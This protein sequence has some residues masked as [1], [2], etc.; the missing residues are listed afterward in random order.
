MH[1]RRILFHQQNGKRQLLLFV[2]HRPRNNNNNHNNNHNNNSNR[3][4]H[5]FCAWL[6]LQSTPLL[7]PLHSFPETTIKTTNALETDVPL[8]AAEHSFSLFL[9]LSLSL[10]LLLQVLLL[11]LCSLAAPAFHSFERILHKGRKLKTAVLCI[12]FICGPGSRPDPGPYPGMILGYGRFS[13]RLSII[14]VVFF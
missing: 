7:S 10:P 12:V 2:K 14:F 6:L 9:R 5:F 4:R 1:K 3:R 13:S 11:L 8:N